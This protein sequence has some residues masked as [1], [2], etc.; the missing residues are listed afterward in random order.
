[1]AARYAVVW[2]PEGDQDVEVVGPYVSEESALA[3]VKELEAAVDGSAAYVRQM[4]P[5]RSVGRL[6]RWRT[7]YHDG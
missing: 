7:S 3:D 2:W 1:M 6:T 5:V 4:W